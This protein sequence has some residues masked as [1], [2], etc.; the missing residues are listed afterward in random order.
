MS[1]IGW[2]ARMPC[3]H[4]RRALPG[5]QRAR[6]D[7]GWPALNASQRERHWGRRADYFFLS[8]SAWWSHLQLYSAFAQVGHFV[9]FRLNLALTGLAPAFSRICTT[10][11]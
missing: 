5:R 8:S 11:G 2:S 4:P 9:M 1:G 3:I 10:V 7:A 6:K